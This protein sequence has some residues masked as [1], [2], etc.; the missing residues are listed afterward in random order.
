MTTGTTTDG[1]PDLTLAMVSYR[2]L[3]GLNIPERARHLPWLPEG[4]VVEVSTIL[5]PTGPR[6]SSPG[7]TPA[8]VVALTQHNCAYESLL[9]DAILEQSRNKAWRAMVLNLLVRD[10]AQGKALL[11]RI[12]P[13][14]G[15]PPG[16]LM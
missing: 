12:W 5:G 9:V 7:V 11:D 10:A 8:D 16:G 13:E 1:T 14:G 3:M 2:D 4:A 6:I 15:V